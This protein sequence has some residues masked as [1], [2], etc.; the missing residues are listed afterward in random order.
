MR[1]VI[2]DRTLQITE[3]SIFG[4]GH[5]ITMYGVKEDTGLMVGIRVLHPMVSDLQTSCPTMLG[6]LSGDIASVLRLVGLSRLYPPSISSFSCTI[7]T[8]TMAEGEKLLEAQ[9]V[10]LPRTMIPTR[11]QK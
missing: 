11:V 7:D 6:R 5:E 8:S 3:R 9:V 1:L 4:Q 2:Y 10:Y